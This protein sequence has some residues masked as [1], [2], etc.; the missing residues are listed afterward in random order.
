MKTARQ[1]TAG[2]FLFGPVLIALAHPS[3]L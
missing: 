1:E 3:F 2:P